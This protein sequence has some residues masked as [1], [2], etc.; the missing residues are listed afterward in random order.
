MTGYIVHYACNNDSDPQSVAVPS[1][2]T[3]ADITDLY[4]GCTYTISVEAQSEHLSGESATVDIVCKF[5]IT[6]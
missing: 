3:A 1:S 5:V 6:L 2:S 4:N